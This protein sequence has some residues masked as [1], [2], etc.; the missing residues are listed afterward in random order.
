[1]TLGE[2]LKAI[3]AEQRHAEEAKRRAAEEAAA[4]LRAKQRYER[5][6][7]VSCIS[8]A[9]DSA[10]RAGKIPMYKI[11]GT[12]HRS[13]I[14]SCHR[15]ETHMVTDLDLWDDLI[16]WLRNED[17]KIKVTEGWEGDGSRSWLQVSVEILP[18][19]EYEAD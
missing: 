15:N 13:W 9:I 19:P 18:G 16:A 8:T 7:L 3:V 5:S 2:K 17:L 14:N 12:D 10:I 11:H 6:E 1:M 4:I